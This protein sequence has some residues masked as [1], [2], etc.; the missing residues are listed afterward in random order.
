VP[1]FFD[2]KLESFKEWLICLL[3]LHELL[4]FNEEY[5]SMPFEYDEYEFKY[6]SFALTEKEF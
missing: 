2:L 1:E 5:D 3:A 4:L 6:K